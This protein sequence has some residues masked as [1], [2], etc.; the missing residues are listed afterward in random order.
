M[1]EII[2]LTMN[3]TL[4]LLA[5][6]PL[7]NTLSLGQSVKGIPISISFCDESIQLPSYRLFG[8]EFSP[9]LQISTRILQTK[10]PI[11]KI[12]F[13]LNLGGFYKKNV[14]RTFYIGTDFFY[15]WQPHAKFNI[16][17]SIGVSGNFHQFP[18]TIYTLNN[19]D[20]EKV[21]QG[22]NFNPL[23]NLGLKIAYN[24]RSKEKSPFYIFTQYKWGMELTFSEAISELPHSFL[25]LG[26]D[27]TIP[28]S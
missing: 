25:S 21:K 4:L 17:P 7:M 20:P 11:H 16:E 27:F 13:H 22:I 3:K 24:M 15:R 19:G 23:P 9:G 10:N 8:G 28:K 6:I 12:G 18:K 5:L 14:A 1:R 2:N 26:V